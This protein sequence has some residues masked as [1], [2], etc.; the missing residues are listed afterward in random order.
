M[1]KSFEDCVK[2]GGKVVTKTL[3]GG[4]YVHLCKTPDGKWTRGEVKTKQWDTDLK[5]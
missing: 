4:K 3:K 5:A 2:N 1:P